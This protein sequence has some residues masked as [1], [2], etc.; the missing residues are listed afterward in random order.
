M[1]VETL[2]PIVSV[3]ITSDSERAITVTKEN[4]FA[5]FVKMWNLQTQK[6]TFEEKIGDG[7]TGYIKI[8]EVE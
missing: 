2:F 7:E 1:E 5:Y 3:M 6:L 8:K 4:D